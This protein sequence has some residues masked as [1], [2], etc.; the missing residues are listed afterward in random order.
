[1]HHYEDVY[2]DE[3]FEDKF[4]DA[5]VEAAG[6]LP[7]FFSVKAIRPA[8]FRDTAERVTM[9][10]F[11]G[12]VAEEDGQPREGFIFGEIEIDLTAEG[13][14]LT[15]PELNFQESQATLG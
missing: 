14:S 1:M 15:I 9:F 4:T 2:A 8:A 10:S 12:F 5:L 11:A 13:Y 6:Q 3:E 7:K